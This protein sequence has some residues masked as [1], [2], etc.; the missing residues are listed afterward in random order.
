MPTIR[1]TAD[2]GTYRIAG[3]GFNPGDERDVDDDLAEYLA[4]RE[5]FEVVGETTEADADTGDGANRDEE[6]DSETFDED[7]WF[8]D[9]DDYQDR[10]AAVEAGDVD[11]HLDVIKEAESSQNV[12]DAVEDRRDELEG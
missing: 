6:S 3:Y 8:D 2:G 4:D 12:I 5:D 11:T 10:V 1:Y 7:T 9:H